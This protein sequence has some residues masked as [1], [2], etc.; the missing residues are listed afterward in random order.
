[1]RARVMCV[2]LY[3]DLGALLFYPSLIR[4]VCRCIIQGQTVCVCVFARVRVC[5][6][7][8]NI[9]IYYKWRG[10]IETFTHTCT[11]KHGH[12]LHT[13]TADL[14]DTGFIQTLLTSP[15]RFG[16]LS[17]PVSFAYMLAL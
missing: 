15:V 9:Y 16:Y 10:F 4:A 14:M 1:V 5:V 3:Q 11:H 12:R 8:C 7:V 17:L 13:D 6:C 2:C